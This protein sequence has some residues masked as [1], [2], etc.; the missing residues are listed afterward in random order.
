MRLC[1]TILLLTL[2]AGLAAAN[3]GAAA[4]QDMATF[5]PERQQYLRYVTTATAANALEQRRQEVALAF[6][7]ASTTR[8]DNFDYCRPVR[9]TPTLWRLDLDWLRWNKNDWASLVA[10]YPYHPT[11]ARNATLVR[12]DWLILQLVD[13]TE[14]DAY[15]RFLFGEVPKNR[16]RAFEILGVV[17]KPDYTFGLIQPDS[18]V[19]VSGDRWIENRPVLRGYAWG[20]RDV[21]K[22][23][24]KSDP[25]ESP[26]GS[27]KHDGEEHI[28]GLPKFDPKSGFRGALQAYFLANGQG[29][30]VARAPVDL[31]RDHQEFRGFAEIRNPGSCIGCHENG[32][33]PVG[34]N[35]L[36]ETIKSGVEAYADYDNYQKI[37][38]FH[39]S[40]LERFVTRD[41]E[42]FQGA[43]LLACG[44]PAAEAS[45]FVKMVVEAYDAPVTL[46]RA[47]AESYLAPIELKRALALGSAGG[48]SLGARLS[49]LAHGGDVP[50][51]AFEENYVA[52]RGIADYWRK[53]Q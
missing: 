29:N 15:L 2:F 34:P 27:F 8:Q 12:A 5:P 37:E 46:E 39:G 26:D 9:V 52:V 44:E 30:L 19:S 28:I 6:V 47:A 50:R 20:T 4:I 35:L 14:S 21:L 33:N 18:G 24:G 53:T 51:D 41:N 22:L 7:V 3:D 40:K 17:D 49:S 38:A 42:D 45:L 36:I 48:Y 23:D 13:Q 10:H 16:A 25:L 1:H 11:G 32:I 43:A 31:V